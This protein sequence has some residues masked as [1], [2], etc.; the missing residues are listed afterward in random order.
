MNV[1]L[2]LSLGV[3]EDT[4]GVSG[5]HK[6][7]FETAGHTR[8]REELVFELSCTEV[9]LYLGDQVNGVTAVASAATVL[10]LDDVACVLVALDLVGLL[11]SLHILVN[12][13]YNCL[14][15]EL[16][17]IFSVRRNLIKCILYFLYFHA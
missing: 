4:L 12:I 14:F 5:G 13:N 17:F 10:D 8:I 11:A 6:G 7:D 9:G 15:E 2:G 16:P 3:K 1:L